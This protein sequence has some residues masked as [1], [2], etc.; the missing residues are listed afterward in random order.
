M[1]LV[2]KVLQ[3]ASNNV[4]FGRKEPYMLQFNE[5]VHHAA[6]T[7]RSFI[8]SICEPPAGKTDRR[9]SM[10]Y[11]AYV[12]SSSELEL[13]GDINSLTV[14]KDETLL[15]LHRLCALFQPKWMALLTKNGLLG[16]SGTRLSKVIAQL[17]PAPPMD[18]AATERDEDNLQQQQPTS[19][20]S[21]SSKA[22]TAT[23]TTTMP[24]APTS[25]LE[26]DD[27]ALYW[28]PSPASPSDTPQ[29]YV[30]ARRMRATLLADANA[31]VGKIISLLESGGCGQRRYDLVFDMTY[32]TPTT[33]LTA[34]FNFGSLLYKQLPYTFRKNLRNGIVL[35]PDRVAR[36]VVMFSQAMASEK[37]NKKLHLCYSWQDLTRWIPANAIA[38][39]EESKSHIL[40]SISVIKINAA[41]KRQ[42]RL[43]KLTSRSLLNIDPSGPCV[44]NERAIGNIARITSKGDRQVALQFVDPQV[45]R[46]RRWEEED[47]QQFAS[48]LNQKGDGGVFNRFALAY[49]TSK[50]SSAS[51]TDATKR[52]YE[53]VNQRERDSFILEIMRIGLQMQR[54]QAASTASVLP[55]FFVVYK[56]GSVGQS[57]TRIW[58]LT[59]DSILNMDTS[60]KVH[61]EMGLASIQWVRPDPVRSDY[62]LIRVLD[63]EE[64]LEVK[65]DW[66]EPF[67][68]ALQD[69]LPRSRDSD[70]SDS[71]HVY[72]A[73]ALL[74]ERDY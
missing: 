61:S 34:I 29:F 3:N 8:S 49:R 37:A 26:L 19:L 24:A 43:V 74:S 58:L 31:L 22:T 52:V 41:G 35:H 70:R 6:K 67:L 13:F 65:T 2:T 56:T 69:A 71:S 16:K 73:I 40:A 51:E 54:H 63:R 33:S 55:H 20:S 25:H 39:P 32:F 57:Q 15:S 72:S 28:G 14:V 7:I 27:N 18:D 9:T 11:D 45:V 59:T 53:F 38:I 46:E 21:S 62:V 12:E 17:G 64:P 47:V 42:H 4:E 10:D 66:R 36:A 48:K 30:I 44:Q 1:L 60:L 5:F 50:S 68:A 23:T